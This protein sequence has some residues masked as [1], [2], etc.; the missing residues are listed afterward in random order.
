MPL[1]VN[2]FMEKHARGCLKGISVIGNQEVM[3]SW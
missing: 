1:Q 3:L 2:S